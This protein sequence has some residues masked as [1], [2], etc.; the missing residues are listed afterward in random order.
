MNI[1]D[2]ISSEFSQEGTHVITKLIDKSNDKIGGTMRL[3]AKKI[4]LTDSKTKNIYRSDLIYERHRHRYTVNGSYISLINKGGLTVPGKSLE[5]NEQ[6]GI[7]KPITEII[8]LK[9]H[10]WYIGCQYHP[11][12]QSNPFNPHPLFLSFI[13]NCIS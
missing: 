9:D 4:L 5:E 12:Y 10:P 8:E 3:G 7:P 1:K 2:A 11:E 6:T 13:E